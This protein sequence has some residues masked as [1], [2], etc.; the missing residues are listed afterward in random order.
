MKRAFPQS[1]LKH[2]ALYVA[3]TAVG[4]AGSL[5]AVR[6]RAAIPDANALTYTGYL[7]SPDGKPLTD[8]VNIRISIW[9][10]AEAGTRVCEAPAPDTV[11]V[12][13]RFQVPLPDLCTEKVRGSGNLW[14][15]TEIDGAS[16]GRTPMGAVPYA[17]VAGSADSAAAATGELAQQVV[18]AGAVMA[19]DLDACPSGW[20]ALPTAKGR[21]IVGVT[22]GLARGALVGIDAFALTLAHLPAHN[23]KVEDPGHVHG[24]AGATFVIGGGD[25]T[26]AKIAQSGN[27]FGTVG[28]TALAFTG[29]TGTASAGGGQAFDNRQASLALLYCKKN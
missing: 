25:P 20:A 22:T 5:L 8:S 29:I 19:F 28:S 9:D 26:P 13:G 6:A 18:P 24:P 7:E 4:A 10:D 27:S 1:S 15:E 16:L 2:L 14:I 3:L 23:H 17:I 11:P 21:A 12:A